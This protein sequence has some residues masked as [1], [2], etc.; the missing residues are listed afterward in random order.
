MYSHL[1]IHTLACVQA[2]PSSSFSSFASRG[3]GTFYA[4]CKGFNKS[5]AIFA[6]GKIY[7]SIQKS[8][9]GS[10]RNNLQKLK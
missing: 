4:I 3:K 6:I 2:S 7:F 5:K 9:E 1:A 10:K 8:K